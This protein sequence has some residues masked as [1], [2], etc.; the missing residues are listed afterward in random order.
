ML[1][2]SRFNRAAIPGNRRSQ[3]RRGIVSRATLVPNLQGPANV[4]KDAR[5]PDQFSNLQQIRKPAVISKGG[6]VAAQSRKAAEVRAPLS[7]RVEDYPL[8]GDGDASDIFP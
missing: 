5:M 4:S 6:I 8:S 3:N 1:K 7:L 2:Q